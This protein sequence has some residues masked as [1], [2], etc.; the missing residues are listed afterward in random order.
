[1]DLAKPES[2]VEGYLNAGETGLLV[3]RPKV[4][5]SRLTMQL[6]I[7]LGSGKPFLGREVSRAYRVLVLDLENR[8][9]AIRERLIKMGGHAKPSVYIY[10]PKTLAESVVSLEEAQ[11]KSGSGSKGGQAKKGLDKL[12]EM[13]EGLEP[14]VLVVD[15]WR[16]LIG[17]QDEN[18]SDVVLQALVKLSKLRIDFGQLSILL[19]HHLRKQGVEAARAS[20]RTDPHSWVES[21]SG[22]HALV[23]HVDFCWGLEREVN[24][25]GDELI[26]F[27]GVARNASS[28]SLLLEEDEETLLFN[29]AGGEAILKAVLSEKEMEIW[30]VAK[31]ITKSFTFTQLCEK[32]NTTNKKAVAAVLKKA[33]AQGQLE[34]TMYGGYR[35]V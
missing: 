28:T 32:A 11:A 8:P 3:G 7:A 4:G 1:M 16:L 19:I 12:R 31:E 29:A 24:E 2:I 30:D 34:K 33:V 14:D 18:K 27:G 13:V 25:S 10:A 26:V 5:K 22:H 20:L 15:T 23:G 6:S 17:A 9:A 35:H 21:V